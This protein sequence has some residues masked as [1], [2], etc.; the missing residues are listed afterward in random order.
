M[1][2]ALD[3]CAYVALGSLAGFLGGLLGIG[4]G[5][6][7]VP[8]LYA[9]LSRIDR[10]PEDALPM[11]LGTTMC[12]ILFTAS[13]AVRANAKRG[14]VRFDVLRRFA[15]YV[16]IGCV[17]GACLATVVDDKY[18]KL[19]FAVFCLY[20]ATR[21]FLSGERREPHAAQ[22]ESAKLALPG[23]FFGSVCGMI[24][25]GGAN[26]FVPFMLKRDVSLRQAIATASALQL[27]I[28]I[29]GT[30]GYVLLGLGK[31]KASGSLGFIY[32]PALLPVI[33]ACVLCAPYGVA[34]SHY[35]RVLTLKKV[36]AGVT[37]VIGL[38][39][40]GVFALVAAWFG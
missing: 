13:S 34:A 20:S 8:G 4:G 19:G 36:F 17:L 38:K 21:M 16:S 27:P 9:M 23:L 15:P 3:L 7:L 1:I 29:A 32:L 37:A 35:V 28:A 10:F 33:V 25:V 26:L 18:V 12:S 11:A 2:Q 31:A 5:F 40:A 24:G 6:V 14:F 30:I 22:I 39:M